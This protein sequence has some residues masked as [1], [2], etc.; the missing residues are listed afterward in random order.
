MAQIS[1]NTTQQDIQECTRI[2][3]D[4]RTRPDH[5]SKTSLWPTNVFTAYFR[6]FTLQTRP[7]QCDKQLL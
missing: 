4:D 7:V 3:D 1:L 5:Q 2:N 6:E